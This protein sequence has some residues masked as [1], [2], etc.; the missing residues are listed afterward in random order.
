MA[1]GPMPS[2]SSTTRREVAGAMNV[3]LAAEIYKRT[4]QTSR[5]RVACCVASLIWGF[6]SELAKIYA[7][8][9]TA[10]FLIPSAPC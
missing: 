3:L 5:L 10:Q 6:R 2:R 8:L 1:L 9:A 7:G 4:F